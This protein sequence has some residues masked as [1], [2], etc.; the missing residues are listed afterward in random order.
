[1]KHLNP[2][3]KNMYPKYLNTKIKQSNRIRFQTKSHNCK[4]EDFH[5]FITVNIKK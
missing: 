5:C 4:M 3:K 1:M 2:L